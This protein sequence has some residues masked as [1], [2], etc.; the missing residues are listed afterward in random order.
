MLGKYKWNTLPHQYH[1]DRIQIKINHLTN[2]V[3]SI[4]QNSK[5]C[6]LLQ[7]KWT[8]YKEQPGTIQPENITYPDC[9]SPEPFYCKY[10]QAAEKTIEYK[11]KIAA[12]ISK[13]LGGIKSTRMQ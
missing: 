2:D 4:K 8:K 7:V 10:N 6:N 1:S 3:N 11:K 13:Y 9:C 12:T 5:N